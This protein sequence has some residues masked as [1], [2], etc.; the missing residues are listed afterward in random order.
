[1][2]CDDDR[3]GW[4]EDGGEFPLWLAWALAGFFV[5]L[6]GLLLLLWADLRHGYDPAPHTVVVTPGPY[7]PPPGMLHAVMAR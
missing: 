3:N 4:Q 7:R 5:T 2:S 1:M 6:A